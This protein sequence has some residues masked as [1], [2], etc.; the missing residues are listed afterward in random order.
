MSAGTVSTGAVVSTTVTVKEALPV[1]PPLSVAEHVTTVTPS[2]KTEP[3]GL[4][5]V[6][7]SGP[8]TRSTAVGV[9]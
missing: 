3:D 4:E 2:G 7:S 1:R 5:Q 9:A 6:A 8:S